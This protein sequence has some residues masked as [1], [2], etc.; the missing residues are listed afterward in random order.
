MKKT[1]TILMMAALV[2]GFAGVSMAQDAGCTDCI[3]DPGLINRGCPADQW[4]CTA[5]PFDFEDSTDW[6]YVPNKG[7]HQY[8]FPYCDCFE[9]LGITNEGAIVDIR[10]EILVDGQ[11]GDHGAYWAEDLDSIGL[12]TYVDE[13]AACDDILTSGK[14]PKE[15]DGP[16]VYKY[17][18]SSGVY[19]AGTVD[20]DD[21]CDF[22]SA[23][24][25]V[26]VIEVDVDSED[27]DELNHGYI[28]D[29]DDERLDRSMWKIDI[30]EI[31]FDVSK[32]KPGQ[33]IQVR[34]CLT[35]AAEDGTISFGGICGDC[36]CCCTLELGT[37]ACCEDSSNCLVYPYA[38]PMNDP[39]WWYGFV[40][41]NL[42]DDAGNATITIYEVDG[43]TA[44]IEVPVPAHGMYVKT[45]QDL[46]T[47]FG[48]TIGNSRAY[49]KVDSDFNVNGF[50]FMANDNTGASM[51]YLPDCCVKNCSSGCSSPVPLPIEAA[52]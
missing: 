52:N 18:N 45:G 11:T 40:V 13:D 47:A 39:N 23:T 10:L 21:N 8:L 42:S 5:E 2:L 29:L 19:V 36:G 20:E 33:K 34:V 4:G 35:K 32:I 28:V 12:K 27:Y 37:L 30:P 7:T 16:F 3:T 31:K 9:E 15:F 17:R 43:D 49:F 50:M 48:G 41:T 46:M 26:T 6:C 44:S 25:R 22:T 38:T 14:F 51:G 1:L 24:E